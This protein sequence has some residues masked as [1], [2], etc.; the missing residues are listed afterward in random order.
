MTAPAPAAEYDVIVIGGGPAGEN[1]AAYAIAG[2]DR[3]A[4]I[5]ERELVGG[6]CSYWACMP[7]KALL[8]PGHVLAAARALPG[9]RAEGL[10]GGGRGGAPAPRGGE[11]PPP[12][13]PGAAALPPPPPPPPAPPGAPGARPRAA[14]PPPPTP[15]P[16]I[17]TRPGT[18]CRLV[19]SREV[20]GSASRRPG[21]SGTLAF[22]P[23][24]S[25]T[26]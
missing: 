3:T 6:E 25:T 18:S 2:S 1:A 11:P 16:M 4:A 9:V 23:V 14:A 19:A 5:V 8:R 10:D 20:H 21:V 26:A 22:V 24:A 12:R 17:A 13:A 7:S 15:P